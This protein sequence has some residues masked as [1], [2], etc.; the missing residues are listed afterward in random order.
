ME[1]TITQ[2]IEEIVKRVQVAPGQAQASTDEAKNALVILWNDPS[3]TNAAKDQVQI[4]WNQ[5]EALEKHNAVVAQVAQDAAVAAIE[6]RNQ[7]NI[8]L[9][10]L[11]TVQTRADQLGDE[12]KEPNDAIDELYNEGTTT[13]ERLSD[14]VEVVQDH[15]YDSGLYL[16]CPGCAASDAGWYEE[17]DHDAVNWVC[18]AL[19]GGWVEGFPVEVREQFSKLINTAGTMIAEAFEKQAATAKA[20]Y[21]DLDA[22]PEGE[23]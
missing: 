20:S 16:G 14:I 12:L 9:D 1:T 4:A 13:N 2:A 18:R 21:V 22:E 5:V 8:A 15:V 3:L 17:L 6:T 10:N 23:E 19:F 11:D 7:L